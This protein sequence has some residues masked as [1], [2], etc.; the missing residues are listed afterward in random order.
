MGLES[1]VPTVL[2]HAAPERSTISDLFMRLA[3]K[4]A[5]GREGG[6]GRGSQ[7]EI[8]TTEYKFGPDSDQ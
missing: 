2:L 7:A 5:A 3:Q 4:L 8:G 1:G 6:G